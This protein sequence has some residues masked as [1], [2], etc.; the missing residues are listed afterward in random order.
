MK[1]VESQSELRVE[2]RRS[3]PIPPGSEARRTSTQLS[4]QARLNSAHTPLNLLL[5]YQR[6]WVEDGSRWK[7]W[8]AAR[9]I[10]KSFAAACEVAR[11]C[12]LRP[13]TTWV[14][15]SAGERQ[16]LEFME[17]VRGWTE[18][19]GLAAAGYAEERAAAEAVLKSASVRYPNGSRVIALP[20]NPDTARGYSANLVLDEF[21]FHQD[22]TAIWRAILPSITNALRGELKVRVLS[23]PNGQGNAFYRLWTDTDAA[24]NTD[25][26]GRTQT[27]TDKGEGGAGAGGWS[28]HRTTI[29]DAAA[30]G[31]P[32]NV[33]EL[34][35]QLND[36]DGWAQEFECQFVDTASVLLPYE[37]IEKCEST[38]A[39]ESTEGTEDE[40]PLTLAL[41]PGGAEGGRRYAGVDIGRKHD[42]TVV[43]VLERIGDVLWT[44]NVQV[45]ERAPFHAQLEALRAV[46]ARVAHCA[47]DAT[48]MG[49][50]LA[51]ELA[52]QFGTGRVEACQFTAQ[53]KQELYPR[54]RRKLEDRLVR[55]PVSRAIREDLHGLQKVTTSAGLVRYAAPRTEDGHCD[56]ATAL[57]LAVRAAEALGQAGLVRAF[58]TPY[59]RAMERRMNRALAG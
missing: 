27:D 42:L 45:L 53:F 28:R 24:G 46:C 13:G 39:T 49:A 4:T 40:G 47:V 10:G 23:T 17:K 57:A 55:I 34:R 30:A 9:Q 58:I 37:L 6:A 48:G 36:P 52:R 38:E 51:E 26:H 7:I 35:R 56:R 32:V 5:P 15:L 41:S 54:L 31:L 43:W 59:G 8:L 14:V 50:M 19:F 44:R 20:A 18:A 22:S 11:D 29:Y 3:T 1:R 25:G 16:A 21:A 2:S 33:E 12:H